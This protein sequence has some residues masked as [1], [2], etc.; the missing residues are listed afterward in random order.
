[1]GQDPLATEK[2][3]SRRKL[4][5]GMGGAGLAGLVI[6]GAGGYLAG[7]TGGDGGGGGGGGGGEV[8]VGS[9]LPLTGPYAADGLEMR[10]G[11][12]LAVDELNAQGGVLGAKIVTQ[13][14]DVEDMAPDKAVANFRRLVG[15]KVAAIITGYHLATGPEIDVAAAAKIPYYGTNTSTVAYEKVA[16]DPQK[17]AT[18]F[19]NL[20][21]TDAWYGRMFPTFVQS[22]VDGGKF[23]PR[24]RKVAIISADNAYSLAIAKTLRGEVGEIGWKTSLFETVVAPVNDWGPTLTKLRQDPPDVIFNTDLAPGDL[25]AFAKQ[26]VQAPTPSLIYGQ[27]GPSVP[28]FLELAGDAANGWLW[29]TVVGRLPDENGAAFAERFEKKFGEKAG[30]SISAITY[31]LT[32]LW[33]Q[34]AALAGDAYDGEKVAHWTVRSRYRGVCGTYWPMPKGHYVRTY[35]AE[36][37]DPSAAQPALYF[38]VQ[39]GAHKIIAFDPFVE[40]EFQLPP[41]MATT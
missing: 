38:Q 15:D 37:D 35:P 32:Y 11:L 21:S 10:R 36:I 41:W 6:G 14:L 1:M 22:L 28:E 29:A 24:N 26:F 16:S 8:T 9:S 25:A 12:E 19:P 13:I 18:S 4:L 34:A 27:Y 20:D 17:Y 23:K 33:A 2:G 40:A 39:S 3:T 30:L 7:D 5:Q 31:D